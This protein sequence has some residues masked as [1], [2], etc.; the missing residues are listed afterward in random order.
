MMQGSL[1]CWDSVAGGGMGLGSQLRSRGLPAASPASARPSRLEGKG[2]YLFGVVPREDAIPVELLQDILELLGG[3][4]GDKDIALRRAP[5]S[6]A[7]RAGEDPR[8]L[9]GRVGGR[10]RLAPF[11]RDTPVR[12]SVG[13]GCCGKRRVRTPHLCP[14]EGGG[15]LLH[16]TP[17]LWT[18]NAPLCLGKKKLLHA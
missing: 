10:L 2:P 14:G 18:A 3:V 17:A 1:Q 13:R 8:E 9:L 4:W 16:H 15:R 7:L 11:P 5:L 6:R 12:T